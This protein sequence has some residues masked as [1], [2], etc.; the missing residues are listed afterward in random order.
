MREHATPPLDRRTLVRRSGCELDE[1]SDSGRCVVPLCH[2]MWIGYYC[3]SLTD[4][5]QL[6][7][8]RQNRAP[9]VSASERLR[10]FH[11]FAVC[12]NAR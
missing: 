10:A 5:I 6:R 7:R 12:C 2:M 8:I 3:V 11:S 9:D 4:S 1:P